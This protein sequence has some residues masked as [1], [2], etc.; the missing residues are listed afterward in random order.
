MLG[1]GPYVRYG[2]L[3]FYQHKFE[4]GCCKMLD[5]GFVVQDRI[6]VLSLCGSGLSKPGSTSA[7]EGITYL[8]LCPMNALVHN[9][10]IP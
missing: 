8:S 4:C 6:Y 1:L 5:L 2:Y 7:G 10:N 9:N 3:A